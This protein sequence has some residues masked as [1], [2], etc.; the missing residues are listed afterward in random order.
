MNFSKI[1]YCP[2]D[3]EKLC[4]DITVVEK[5]MSDYDT[6][7]H[8]GLWRALPICGI[9]DSQDDFHNAEAFERAWERR[10]DT[11][12]EVSYSQV[13]TNALPQVI[14]HFHKLPLTITHAQILSQIA[15]V[16]KHYD[17]KNDNGQP[18]S[19]ID[20]SPG[21]NDHNEPC[22]YKILLNHWNTLSFYVAEGFGKSN[23]Y[24][25]LPESTNTFV[26][27][28]KTYPHGAKMPDTP[29]YIISIFGRIIDSSRHL[30]LIEKSAIKFSDYVISF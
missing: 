8:D 19:Y 23:H 18:G 2:V 1:A 11:D 24:I 3:I 12:G 4:V 29:K 13:I 20:D 28:E 5:L 17:L 25:R 6:G 16:G 14:E 21:L 30:A 10:Y 15:D 27:N 22:S 7:H 26:I 9:V